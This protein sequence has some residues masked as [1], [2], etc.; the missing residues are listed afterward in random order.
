MFSYLN[1]SQNSFWFIPGWRFLQHTRSNHQT[2]LVKKST[3]LA[4][5]ILS[6][7]KQIVLWYMASI[8]WYIHNL[9]LWYMFS[10]SWSPTKGSRWYIWMLIYICVMFL[11]SWVGCQIFIFIVWQSW[12]T[13]IFMKL[14]FTRVKKTNSVLHRKWTVQ[15]DMQKSF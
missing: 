9:D 10:R 3:W 7:T 6:T 15:I 5:S 14:E 13:D 2:R 11:S 1:R 12:N 8:I 4:V